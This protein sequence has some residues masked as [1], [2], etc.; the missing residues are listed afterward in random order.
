VLRSRDPEHR[1]ALLP[2]ASEGRRAR[3]GRLWLASRP[4]WCDRRNRLART[5]TSRGVLHP[6]APE[7]QRGSGMSLSET[8][9]MASDVATGFANEG[10]RRWTLRDRDRTAGQRRAASV[11]CARS[12]RVGRPENG[13]VVGHALRKR[14][15]SRGVQRCAAQRKPRF[16]AG[17]P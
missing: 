10:K 15:L 5:R 6:D 7:L 9:A 12:A 17:N 11:A 14:T 13:R 2:L 8:N 16:V 3:L 1:T 4:A